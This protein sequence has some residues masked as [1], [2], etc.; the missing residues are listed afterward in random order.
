[1]K[2]F[3]ITG[4]AGYVAPRHLKAIKETGNNLVAALDPHDSVG[5]LDSFFPY[6]DFFT[7]HERFERHLEKLRTCLPA[8][9]KRPPRQAEGET[10]KRGE[11]DRQVQE[12]TKVDFLTVCSPNYLHDSH[13]RLGLRCG[14]NVI[15]EKPLVL[16]PSNLEALKL[17][18]RETGKRVFTVMQLRY[19]PLILELK[20]KINST[21]LRT[22]PTVELTY[23]TSRGRWYFYSWKGED[24]KSGGIATNI[25]IHLFD[26]LIWLFGCVQESHVYLSDGKRMSGLL[27]LKNANVVWYLSIDENDLPAQIKSIGKKT[28][29]SILVRNDGK[30]GDDEIEFTDGFSDL[31]TK[32][33]EEVLK[34]KGLGIDDAFPSIETVYKMRFEKVKTKGELFHPNLG[35]I[36]Q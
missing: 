19:H 12:S 25:G 4:I 24:E 5:I 3:A 33:Y 32:V 10:G 34:G 9:T 8:S 7:E 15:C 23:V 28:F 6:A 29:R 14:A 11:P 20:K 26:L 27:E 18:E 22:K 30:V 31:H 17:V 21:Q 13:I 16:N 1:M 35:G 2:K 36:K